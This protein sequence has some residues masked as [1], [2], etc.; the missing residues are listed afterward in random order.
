MHAYSKEEEFQVAM[1]N[2]LEN[3]TDENKKIY[4]AMV[5]DIFDFKLDGSES[6]AKENLEKIAT[7][8]EELISLKQNIFGFEVDSGK[9]DIITGKIKLKKLIY[10]K[11]VS[12]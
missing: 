1:N 11:D 3:P 9:N 6:S 8:K 12:I 2:Y 5:Q 10:E 4:N 7:V